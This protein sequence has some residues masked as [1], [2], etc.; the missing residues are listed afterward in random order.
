MA[1]LL[2]VRTSLLAVGLVESGWLISIEPMSG[3]LP[4]GSGRLVVPSWPKEPAVI[5]S[6]AERAGLV[7]GVLQR[8]DALGAELATTGRGVD[9]GEDGIDRYVL[10]VASDVADDI[11][12][13]D[14]MTI[15]RGD[16]A[17]DVG[18]KGSSVQ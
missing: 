18:G 17:G 2:P 5:G 3:R 7:S 11:A 14:V 16:V 10:A 4:A 1:A 9:R 13:E 12:A 15:A 6:A 8:H